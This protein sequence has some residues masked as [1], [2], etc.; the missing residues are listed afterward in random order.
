MREV[1][2]LSSARRANYHRSELVW[3]LTSAARAASSSA[4]RAANFS[5]SLAWAAHAF[6]RSTINALARS[7][8]A[9]MSSASDGDIYGPR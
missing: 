4:F 9:A 7:I 6:S 8:R 2:A 5:R 3:T 1:A